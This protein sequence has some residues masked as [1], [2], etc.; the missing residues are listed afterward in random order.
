ML[1]VEDG[2]TQSRAPLTQVSSLPS[3]VGCGG[4]SHVSPSLRGE[5]EDDFSSAASLRP[6]PLRVEFAGMIERAALR[7]Q[8]PLPPLPTPKQ[9][10]DMSFGSWAE[11]VKPVD[12]PAPEVRG[13]KGLAEGSWSAPAS[14]HT[15]IASFKK[16]DEGRKELSWHLPLAGSSARRSSSSSHRQGSSA[17]RRQRRHVSATASAAAPAPP[18]TASAPAPPPVRRRLPAPKLSVLWPSKK[19]RPS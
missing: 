5:L 6:P 3:H 1:S 4:G 8:L 19:P 16:T 10:S 13:F 9:P 15:A 18:A 12:S 2:S 14:V 17:K 11:R 7:I